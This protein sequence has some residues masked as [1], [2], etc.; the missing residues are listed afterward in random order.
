M[1]RQSRQARGA[2]TTG[3]GSEPVQLIV[4]VAGVLEDEAAHFEVKLLRI[5]QMAD[6]SQRLVL[7][8]RFDHELPVPENP[9]PRPTA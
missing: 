1:G 6:V 7:A 9:A 4:R 8:R 2:G 5:G 3:A